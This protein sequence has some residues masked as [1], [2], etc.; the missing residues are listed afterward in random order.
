[1]SYNIVPVQ[2]RSVQDVWWQVRTIVDKGL[3]KDDRYQ[4]EDILVLLLKK[5]LQLCVIQ[6]DKQTIAIVITEI[7]VYPRIKECTVM[8]L[9]GEDFKGWSDYALQVIG[10]WAYEA[11]CKRARMF[12]RLGWEK[13]LKE[14]WTRQQVVMTADLQE[15]CHE[16]QQRWN[17]HT[18]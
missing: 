15:V 12:G 18:N 4:S 7:T 10:Q 9:A 11:G 8:L 13:L 6:R 17:Y 5:E 1:M 14:Q 16:W 2:S 3:A